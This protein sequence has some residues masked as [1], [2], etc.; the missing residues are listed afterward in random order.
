M[1]CARACSVR[2]ALVTSATSPSATIALAWREP[3]CTG[4]WSAGQCQTCT[5]SSRMNA[6]SWS[7]LRAP[8]RVLRRLKDDI[9]SHPTG[10]SGFQRGQ[11][12]GDLVGSEADHSQPLGGAGD[13]VREDAGR[14]SHRLSGVG[15]SPD[16]PYLAASV[17]IDGAPCGIERERESS[18]ADSWLAQPRCHQLSSTGAELGSCGDRCKALR[19]GTVGAVAGAQRLDESSAVSSRPCLRQAQDRLRKLVH[20]PGS[21]DAP[22][23]VN[24]STSA[25]RS[26]NR[27]PRS[28]EVS[29]AN[30]HA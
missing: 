12:P 27:L 3:P 15:P 29:D 17:G 21:S 1:L 16:R 24:V 20:G 11:R 22:L 19:G 18:S 28:H 13:D 26:R 30:W 7:K 8:P 25:A 5:R 6:G 9:N 2:F 4:R 14:Q 10:G 23:H